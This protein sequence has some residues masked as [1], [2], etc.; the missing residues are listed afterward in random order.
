MKYGMRVRYWLLA[1]STGCLLGLNGCGLT[2]QQLAQI[3]SSVLT[4]GLNVIVTQLL[5]GAVGGTTA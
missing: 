5:T 2:D 3:W 1:A 4:T